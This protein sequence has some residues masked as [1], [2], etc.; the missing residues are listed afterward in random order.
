V[1]WI[2]GDLEDAVSHTRWNANEVR[3]S[4]ICVCL[5]CK[6]YFSSTSVREWRRPLGNEIA[7]DIPV[8]EQ[9]DAICPHCKADGVIGDK[10]GLPIQNPEFIDALRG[11]WT[12]KLYAAD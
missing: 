11:V 10:T 12:D 4:P 8:Q 1:N 2:R 7:A 9:A 3:S 5:G 6:K